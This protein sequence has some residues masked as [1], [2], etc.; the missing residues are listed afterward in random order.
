MATLP[1]SLLTSPIL[2]GS[3]RRR[4]VVAALNPH[5]GEQGIL[6]NEE[7]DEI[8]PA[9]KEMRDLY[10]V[11]GPL[12]ADSVFHL[13]A[14][15]EYDIVLSLYHDQGHIAA[16]MLD[17]NGTVSM[18]IGLPFLRTSVDHGTAFDIAGRG[19]ADATSMHNAIAKC[20]VYSAKYL[21][22]YKAIDQSAIP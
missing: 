15:G 16:K 11:H 14:S 12:A 9:V 22:N 19:T 20:M 10:D 17:F 13:A 21:N 7:I 18:N 8:A 1:A 3:E 2:I 5:A 6:G 4:I